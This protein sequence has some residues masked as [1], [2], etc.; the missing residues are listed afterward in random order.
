MSPGFLEEKE[1]ILYEKTKEIKDPGK[2]VMFLF[3]EEKALGA[4]EL[5]D[6]VRKESK[7]AISE[8]KDMEI[9]YLILTGDNRYIAGWV[10]S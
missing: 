8:L 10:A 9:K 3:N 2:T 6:I 7:E 5:A 1:L 4:F